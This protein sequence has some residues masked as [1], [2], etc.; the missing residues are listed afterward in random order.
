MENYGTRA[1]LLTLQDGLSVVYM[2][3]GSGRRPTRNEG[4]FETRPRHVP[5][6][7]AFDEDDDDEETFFSIKSRERQ[8]PL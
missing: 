4:R 2:D 7:T 8:R 3:D 6:E 1:H 5:L